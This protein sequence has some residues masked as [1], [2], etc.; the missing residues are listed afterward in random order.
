MAVTVAASGKGQDDCIEWNETYPPSFRRAKK[1]GDL[2]NPDLLEYGSHDPEP[3][4]ITRM[5]I[6]GT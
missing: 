1:T 3:I 2:P 6:T 5:T 4:G